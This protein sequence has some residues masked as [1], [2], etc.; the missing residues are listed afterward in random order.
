[1]L[2]LLFNHWELCVCDLMAALDI[3]QSKASR[4]LEL[5]RTTLAKRPDAVAL[6]AKL[7]DWLE[8]KNRSAVCAENGACA[9]A[10]TRRSNSS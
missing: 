2:W 6:L 9:A 7:H 5:L 4:H 10:T 3:T 1:M 8:A